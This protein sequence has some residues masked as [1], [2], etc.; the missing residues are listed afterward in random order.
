VES[1]GKAILETTRNSKCEEEVTARGRKDNAETQTAPRDEEN[2]GF[3][4]EGCTPTNLYEP[5]EERVLKKAICKNMKT[6]G[7]TKRVAG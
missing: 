3:W 6:K 1:N 4:F 2:R 5:Q 7:G